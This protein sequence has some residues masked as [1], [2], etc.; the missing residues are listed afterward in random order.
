MPLALG[1]LQ[2]SGQIRRIPIN[3]RLDQQRYRY[4]L[5]KPNPTANSKLSIPEAYTELARRYFR[6]I[7]PVTVPE[8]QWF[9]GLGVKAAKVAVEPMGLV[10]ATPGSDR[11]MFAEDRELFARFKAPTKPAYALISSMDSVFLLRRN[12]LSLLTSDGSKQEVYGDKGARELGSLSDLPSNAILDR[13][14][15]VGLWEYDPS[16]GSIAWL[17]FT[18]PDK[19]LRE[20]LSRTEAYIR[21]QLGDARSFSLDSPKSRAPRINAIRK[22]R[23]AG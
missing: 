9:S 14:A 5:W 21:D 20:S 23:Q 10:P 16:S 13:G 15:I 12:L 22:G 4:A 2:V 11:F 3:G 18:A 19:A 6:W 1:S 8:F 7:G 17:S